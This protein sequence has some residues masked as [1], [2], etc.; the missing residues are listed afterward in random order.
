MA[1]PPPPPP[2]PSQPSTCSGCPPTAAQRAPGL[3]APP[4]PPA[5]PKRR[6]R[7]K[8]A[9]E[10][11]AKEAAEG[12]APSLPAAAVGVGATANPPRP[13]EAMDPPPSHSPKTVCQLSSADT[14]YLMVSWHPDSQLLLTLFLLPD[15]LPIPC[16]PHPRF[17]HVPSTRLNSLWTFRLSSRVSSSRKPSLM[18]PSATT[19]RA[20]KLFAQAL[21]SSPQHQDCSSRAELNTEGS[22][23]SKMVQR[24]LHRAT[25][26]PGPW[27][28]GGS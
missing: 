8:G 7:P 27:P 4:L 24:T 15:A 2:A 11:A 25:R 5:Q 21:W 18:P 26:G 6:G 19:S 3:L 14:R 9:P 13:I 16:H 17:I 28:T 20:P 23:W 1:A 10:V 12:T 22:E